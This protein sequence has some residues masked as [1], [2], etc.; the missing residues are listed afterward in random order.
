MKNDKPIEAQRKRF[1][2]WNTY[3]IDKSLSLRLG[4]ASTIQDWDV[5][6]P[7]PTPSNSN[8]TPLSAFISLWVATA[9]CQGHIYE[10]LYSPD[11]MTQSDDV[12]RFRAQK[13]VAD[14]DDIAR[15]SQELS[16]RA[17]ELPRLRLILCTLALDTN[18][19]DIEDPRKRSQDKTW[20]I[21]LRLHSHL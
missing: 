21:F 7:L 12:R 3:F 5:T 4:R 10:L 14:L 8:S 15:R 1:L 18:M 20:G 9:R 11:S 17:P 2:F 6:V 13:L 16:V 19:S